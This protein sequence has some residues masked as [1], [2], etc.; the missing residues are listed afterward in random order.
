MLKYQERFF[1]FEVTPNWWC[2]TFGDLPD[3]L[4]NLNESIKDTFTVID[5]DMY[6]ARDLLISTLREEF[7]VMFG[8][9]IK[10]YDL[11]IANAIYQGFTP[12]QV[13]LV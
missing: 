9:N 2:V 7:H 13:F 3:D 8:Y 10:G 11:V 1:D 5:S 4:D 12:Q 6:N